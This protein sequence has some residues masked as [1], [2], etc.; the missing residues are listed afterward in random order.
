[1]RK[2]LSTLNSYTGRT[3]L[4]REDQLAYWS[5]SGLLEILET[6]Y[7]NEAALIEQC[8]EF[9]ERHKG[10]INIDSITEHQSVEELSIMPFLLNEDYKNA[11]IAET[12]LKTRVSK[13]LHT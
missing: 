5:V 7:A 9:L 1:L 13:G 2:K 6:H 12:A 4:S 11:F 10:F 8:I 3:K